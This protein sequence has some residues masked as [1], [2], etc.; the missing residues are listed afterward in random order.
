MAVVVPSM[1]RV[2]D[3]S[4]P[5][6]AGMPVFPTDPAPVVLPW[7]RMPVH[8]FDTEV[9]H[10]SSHTGTHMDAPSH[11]VRGATAIDEVDVAGCFSPGALLD[12]R[13]V[14][15]GS[16]ID[17]SDLREAEGRSGRCLAQGNAVLLW[18]GW[19]RR[20]RRRD[21]VTGYP[22]LSEDGARCLAERGASVVGIDTANIDHPGAGEFPA[23]R[24]LL[25]AGIPIVENLTRLGTIR[26]S[27]FTF[28]ALPPAIASA[29]GSP[30]RA[31]VVVGS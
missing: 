28:V 2:I 21:Y 20:W 4:H 30:V 25:S 7:A 6:K 11:F 13:G 19:S 14:A 18:T 31:V 26:S 23:H 12:L 17:P 27:S 10:L 15:P 22:G 3:L 1:R 5:I 24:A 29:T 9:L 16:M 8:P